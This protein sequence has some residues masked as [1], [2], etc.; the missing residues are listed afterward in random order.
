M[1]AAHSRLSCGPETHLFNQD[2]PPD[3]AKLCAAR[4]WPKRAI[5]Y[6]YSID[7]LGQSPPE[8]Y[9][10]SR[11][12]IETYLRARPPSLAAILG[13]LT[14]Q[15]M[16][17]VGK[18]RWVEKTPGHCL[19]V[20]AIRQYFPTSPI[21]RIVRDPRDVALSLLRQKW[22]PRSHIE[23]I[24]KWRAFEAISA[25]FCQTDP[26]TFTLRYKDLVLE[27]EAT[28]RKVCDFIGEEFEARML[29]TSESIQ[30]VN[31]INDNCQAKAGTPPD[32]SRIADWI[33]ALSDQE[34]R[35][36]E[37]VLGNS[38]L[39][40]GYACRDDFKGYV[41]VYPASQSRYYWHALQDFVERGFRFWPKHPGERPTHRVY[42]GQPDAD[43]WLPGNS[44]ARL[45]MTVKIRI[46]LW[47]ARPNG[48]QVHWLNE[49]PRKTEGICAHLLHLGL[50]PFSTS[51]VVPGAAPLSNGF[52][53]GTSSAH[54]KCQSPC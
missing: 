2:V 26:N 28:L 11:E 6:L 32:P 17:Q 33:N 52:P 44:L 18:Q 16:I 30:H 22:G 8:L 34:N 7:I 27:P 31:K 48:E 14:E 50:K 43:D 37:A 49:G 10:F 47:R 41:A 36:F 40:Y 38:L 53:N 13:T 15:H 1:L 29:D 25:P 4:H 21:I 42:L 19:C 45:W 9:G 39:K 20:H 5:E 54:S 51:T 35:V 3:A 12:Q 23:C 24:W 46:D